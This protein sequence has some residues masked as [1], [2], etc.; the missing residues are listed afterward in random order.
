[1]NPKSTALSLRCRVP[2]SV[3]VTIWICGSSI[4]SLNAASIESVAGNG[5]KGYGG[6]GGPAIA[7]ELAFPCGVAKGPDGAL[8]ICDTE[9]HRVRKVTADG[10]IT[11]IDKNGRSTTVPAPPTPPSGNQQKKR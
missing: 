11:T 7:A 10:K 4:A 5:T 6:D 8:Y 1:M 3:F 2:V 9:N